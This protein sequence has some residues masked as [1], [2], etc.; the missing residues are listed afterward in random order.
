MIPPL[1][2]LLIPKSVI[3]FNYKIA[4]SDAYVKV[5]NIFYL[6]CSESNHQALTANLNK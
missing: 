6:L 4:S 3:K 5:T 1:L 2:K